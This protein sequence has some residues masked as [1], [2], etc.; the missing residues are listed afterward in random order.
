[1]FHLSATQEEAHAFFQCYWFRELQS[2]GEWLKKFSRRKKKVFI[3]SGRQIGAKLTK[4]FEI[5]GTW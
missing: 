4:T 1:M 2:E 5:V 3:E